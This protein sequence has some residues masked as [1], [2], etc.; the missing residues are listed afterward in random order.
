[1][2]NLMVTNLSVQMT[3]SEI[4]EAMKDMAPVCQSTQNGFFVCID[5]Y[6]EDPRELWQ[7]P[8][9][10]IFFQKLISSGFIAFLE[11]S[12][13]AEG[14]TRLDTNLGCPGFGALEIWMIANDMMY[15][16]RKEIRQNELRRFFADLENANA[17]SRIVVSLPK[18]VCDGQQKF[19]GFKTWNTK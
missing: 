3:D 6:E 19:Q 17:K 5:G 4:E 14:L 7:I 15:S 12:A 10:K 11:V 13:T 2:Q 9:V 16:G 8:E 1:M 18:N